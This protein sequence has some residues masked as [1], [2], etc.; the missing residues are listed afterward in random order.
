MQRMRKLQLALIGA[1]IVVTLGYALR[2]GITTAAT[3]TEAKQT[4]S[5]PAEGLDY[6][7]FL[8]S[9]RNHARLPVSSL[10]SS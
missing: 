6:S 4:Q 9:S 8:H 10:P 3:T 7:K 5:Q 1:V 2:S